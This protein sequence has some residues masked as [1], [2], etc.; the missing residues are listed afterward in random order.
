MLSEAAKKWLESGERG[1]SS[2]TLFGHL[3]GIPL[4]GR[5]GP[6]HPADPSDL[7]R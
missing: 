3:T 4:V 2:E 5:W 1:L 6:H 7:R